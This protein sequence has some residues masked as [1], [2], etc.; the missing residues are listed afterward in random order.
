MRARIIDCVRRRPVTSGGP[1]GARQRASPGSISISIFACRPVGQPAGRE[2]TRPTWSRAAWRGLAGSPARWP[3]S[4]MIVLTAAVCQ[5]PLL[6]RRRP[7]CEL[8]RVPPASI[9]II[10]R[11]LVAVCRRCRACQPSGGAAHVEQL[12]VYLSNAYKDTQWLCGPAPGPI[13]GLHFAGICLCE[14][15]LRN[16]AVR[17]RD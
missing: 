15:R 10:A 8:I 4:I 13:S 7:K 5:I 2:T 6:F 14:T 1:G 9:L 3:S 12:R 16:N 17:R 11:L